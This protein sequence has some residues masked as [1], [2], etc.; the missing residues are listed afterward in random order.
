M[1]RAWPERPAA[2]QQEREAMTAHADRTAL[3]W[4]G[5]TDVG[6]VR[7]VNQDNYVARPESDL[8]VVADGMGGHRGGEVASEIASLTVADTFSER[9][10]DGLID[11]IEQ[12]NAAVHDAGVDDPDLSGMGTTVVAL[13]VV[14]HEDADVVAIANVGDSRCYRFADGE[15]DQV[16]SDHSLVADLVREGSLSPEEA[17]VHPQRNI[18]TRVLGVN[19]EVP[20]D[21]FVVDPR[22]GDRYL[23]CS[24]GLFNEV[25]EPGIA[26]VL[27]RLREPSDAAH[28]L[29][30]LAVEGGGRD[31]VT[32]LV[33]DV[34]D[35]GGRTAA[36]SAALGAD[37]LTARSSAPAPSPAY[38]DATGGTPT[39][40]AWR[41]RRG[42]TA[43]L[44]RF[45]GVD[46]PIVDNVNGDLDADLDDEDGRRATRGGRR[47]TWRVA[48]FTVLVLA[49]VGGVVAT[50]QWYGSS[51]YFVGFEGDTV[52]IYKGRPG[53]LLWIDPELVEVTDLER[54]RVPASSR[55][56][57]TSG[58]EQTSLGDAHRYVANMIEQADERTATTTTTAPPTTTT[59]APRPATTAPRPP[60]SPT[61]A[62]PP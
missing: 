13:A 11:A 26:S 2:K 1:Q 19:D 39:Q 47:L 15:L 49:L 28:E 48:L 56:D 34:V 7:P 20:V 32:V 42:D 55:E 21:V 6:R 59:T 17:A 57:I 14:H 46:D 5:A 44:D 62:P 37:P 35:D 22:L 30:R 40:R 33:I 38:A 58:V 29:V 10:V 8:F 54:D 31:N 52:A 50:I 61:T 27:R 60:G 41:D 43:E 24:D 23:L 4:G 16:T 36:A 53:G 51:A 45:V 3:R 18:V 12:A 25:P 9:T